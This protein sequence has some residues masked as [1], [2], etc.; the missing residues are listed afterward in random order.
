[1]R[2]PVDIKTVH[3]HLIHLQIFVWI[4]LRA[5]FSNNESLIPTRW[6]GDEAAGP[7]LTRRGSQS[8]EISSHEALFGQICLRHLKGPGRE[9]ANQHFVYKWAVGS[10]RML[11]VRQ[12]LWCK[13]YGRE[14]H[15]CI[16][17]KTTKAVCHSEAIVWE[18]LLCSMHI[19]LSWLIFMYKSTDQKYT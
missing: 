11:R 3:T 6:R 5:H 9:S 18:N 2:L 16:L 8:V 15:R 14:C 17:W 12:K 4:N 19:S 7:V 10:T 13:L 1:M